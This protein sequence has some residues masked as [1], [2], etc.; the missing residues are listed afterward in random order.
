MSSQLRSYKREN[1]YEVLGRAISD[2][3][4][5]GEKILVETDEH[6]RNSTKIKYDETNT[7]N[8]NQKAF[9]KN[10]NTFK[11]TRIIQISGTML[12]I[13]LV[14]YAFVKQ[15]LFHIPISSNI[16]SDS[17]LIALGLFLMI[18][19]ITLQFL[20][21]KK[22]I[23][24]TVKDQFLHIKSF[25]SFY[26]TI[27]VKQVANC[28]VNILSKSSADKNEILTNNFQK[29]RYKFDLD[30]GLMIEMKSGSKL[31]IISSHNTSFEL[32]LYK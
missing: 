14:I 3:I 12:I 32:P 1:N 6:K 10:N 13:S 7:Q 21:R 30:A 28:R 19:S 23:K 9:F 27:P 16:F 8:I 4:L 15:A 25:P 29:K 26:H 11:N 18:S 24:I 22:K 5:I 31:I 2:T 17:T 20:F